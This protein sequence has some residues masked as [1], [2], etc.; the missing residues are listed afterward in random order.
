MRR[1]RGRGGAGT[2][3]Q[4]VQV[5]PEL[6]LGGGGASCAAAWACAARAAGRCRLIRLRSHPV[7]FCCAVFCCAVYGPPVSNGGGGGGNSTLERL[8]SK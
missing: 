3:H 6:L 4:A 5:L 1:L 2:T 8:R 7:V